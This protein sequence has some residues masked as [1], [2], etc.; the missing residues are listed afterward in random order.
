MERAL[1]PKLADYNQQWLSVSGA[2]VRE[3][4]MLIK[5]GLQT[6]SEVKNVALKV[7]L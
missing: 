4:A 5:T 6:E 7:L 3:K 1:C 2:L